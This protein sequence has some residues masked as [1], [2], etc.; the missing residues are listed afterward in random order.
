MGAWWRRVSVVLNGFWTWVTGVWA[1]LVATR[2]FTIVSA[3]VI[4]MLSV[5]IGL[6]IIGLIFG[7]WQ[8]DIKAAMDRSG[9]NAS[10]GIANSIN[11]RNVHSEAEAGIF[12]TITQRTPAYLSE[13]GTSIA[14]HS[15]GKAVILEKGMQVMVLDLKRLPAGDRHE[16]MSRVMVSNPDGTFVEGNN[17]VFVPSRLVGWE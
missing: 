2:A 8:P 10:I 12:A 6:K 13:N 9:N 1:S 14:S 7:W 4:L 11:K 16:G 17:V 15:N 3:I 5:I